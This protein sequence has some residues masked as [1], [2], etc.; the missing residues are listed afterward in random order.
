MIRRIWL[1]LND[2]LHIKLTIPRVKLYYLVFGSL[3]R[4]TSCRA[5]MNWI[6]ISIALGG[7][8]LMIK[9]FLVLGELYEEFNRFN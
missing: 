8:Y 6:V 5:L 4:I 7:W 3:D 9:G 2:Y 1:E